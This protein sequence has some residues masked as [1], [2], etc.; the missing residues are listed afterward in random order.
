[1]KYNKVFRILAL[2]A[3]LALLVLVIPATPVLAA[4]IML[5][6]TSGTA[7]T[8]VTM[9]GTGFDSPTNYVGST[10]YF[11]FNYS[12]IASYVVPA[13]TFS[14]TFTVPSGASAGT[15]PVIVQHT[16]P[17]YDPALQIASAM[18]TVTARGV[19]ISPTSGYV[20]DTVT[21]TGSGFTA[22]STVTIYF[23]TTSVG[24]VT[25]TTSGAFTTFTFTV[26]E[27]Y[28]GT[29]TVKGSGTGGDS[30]TVSFTVSSK[31]TV[32][33]ASGAVGDTLTI[34]G[35]GFAASSNI[36]FYFDVASVS[37]ATATTGSTGSFT[38]NTF[39]I[40]S[41]SRGS[42]TIK[43]QDA[44]GNYATATFSV[45]HKITI[46]PASGSSGIEVVVTG[47]GFGGSKTITIKY[48][49][50]AVATDPATITTDPS[51]NFTA[52]FDVPA[53]LAGTYVV[54]AT[55]GTNI[56]TA[57]FVST[58]DATVSPATSAAAPGYVGDTLTITGTGF[59]PNALVTITYT[60]E[61][62]TLATV[63]ADANGNFSVTVTIPPSAGGS[64]TITVS[65]GTA[66]KQFAFV[67]ELT[68]PEIPSP[69]LPYMDDKADSKAYFDW[70]DVTDDSEPVTY[71]LQIATDANFTNILVDKS[72][73]TAS[74][75]TLT[76]EEKL[77][78]TSK[79]EPYCWRI[80]A[81]DAASNVSDWSGSGKF[82]VGFT[83]GF[84]ELEGWVLYAVIGA[85]AIVVFLIGL[86]VGRR[87]GGEEY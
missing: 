42:H 48:N 9:N 34:N 72:G 49:T 59:T 70:G 77:E 29:H 54:E 87:T 55:D 33:P 2:A 69:L 44:S 8:T 63:T 18:F 39:T 23:D 36:T 25:T 86:W 85:G 64:H 65:D 73:L 58:T 37:T 57:D 52:S 43:A 1:V 62:V 50:A 60:S 40:P 45:A 27:S 38:N 26:P 71:D 56:A 76:D 53:G 46:N 83:F 67:M 21:V 78:S 47:S 16:S 61:T 31:I 84:P 35:T 4:G 22:S 51:G 74:E 75:Y 41:T 15:V 80:R 3:I 68:P 79:E 66:T 82:Y 30:S 12:Y 32:T 10:V 11:F 20:G 28:R 5:S 17:T 81:I 24:T 7:G 6:P 13:A 14:T 19:T